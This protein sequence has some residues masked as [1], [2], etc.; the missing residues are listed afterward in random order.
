MA[1]KKPLMGLR[2]DHAFTTSGTELD[3]CSN[4]PGA[5]VDSAT[6]DAKKYLLIVADS[7]QAYYS[8]ITPA[9]RLLDDS[10]VWDDE[11]PLSIADDKLAFW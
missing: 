1:V 5:A 7:E 4:M 9:S 6:Y 10:I 2:V 8:D 11:E 3:G